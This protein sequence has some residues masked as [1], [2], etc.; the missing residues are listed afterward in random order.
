MRSQ[1]KDR[2]K[3][4]F[5]LIELLVVIAI[6]A[7]LAAMLLPVLAKAKDAGKRTNCLSNLHQIGIALLIY[8]EDSG[9]YVPRGNRPIWW[10]VLTPNLGGRSTNDYK[11]VRI[12]TCPSYPDK[13]QLICYV[14]NAWQFSS[15]TDPVGWEL[16]GLSK[17]SRIQRP[18]DTI[19]LADNEHGSWRPIIMELGNTGSDEVNDVWNPE[20]L[21]YAPGG[22]SLKPERRVAAARH[23]RGPNLLFFDGH[24][25][26]KK[27]RLITVDD[28]RE[29]RR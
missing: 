20:F 14:V 6:I 8:A 25:A 15:P 5:T 23:G 11:K 27:S 3:K 13:K 21:P 29:V 28:W 22:T 17:M 1:F 2:R 7:I 4:G 10:Q 26:L 9:G 16:I 19:Y 24:S 12:Y 18:V